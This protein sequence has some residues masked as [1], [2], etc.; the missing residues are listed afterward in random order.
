MR[1]ALA[2]IVLSLTLTACAEAGSQTAAP[3]PEPPGP[4][5]FA[6]PSQ[7][8]PPTVDG[9]A[10]VVRRVATS[11]P[12]VFLTIDDGE[13]RDPLAPA[14]MKGT[15]P[16]L[17]LNT[18]H[19]RADPAY[20]RAIPAAHGSHTVT[21]PDLRG[22]RYSAQ[23]REICGD[24]DAAEKTFGTRPT[25]FRPPYGFY[26]DTTLRVAADCGMKA[27]VMW[28][29]SITDGVVHVEDGDRLRPGDIV[30]MHFTKTFAADYRAFVRQVLADGLTAMPLTDFLR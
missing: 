14:L 27:V 9:L 29:A 5:L 15:H 21:H 22:W 6:T 4:H 13:V 26:D 25:L 10:P 2:L 11:K 20:F 23:H 28:S 19:V 16:T 12:Y 24:A 18:K 8:A 17:F 3:R 30:L 7:Q 1:K